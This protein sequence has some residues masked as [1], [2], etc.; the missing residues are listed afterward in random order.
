M[1]LNNYILL[2]FIVGIAFYIPIHH[3]GATVIEVEKEQ[4]QYNRKLENAVDDSLFQLVEKDSSKEVVLNKEKVAE[5]FYQ[6]LCS[7]FGLLTNSLQQERLKQCVPLLLLTDKDGFYVNV[8]T[9]KKD[10]NGNDKI[11]KVWSKKERYSY[12]DETFSYEFTLGNEIKLY[13]KKGKLLLEG[14]YYNF[15]GKYP[16][17]KILNEPDVFEKTRRMCIINHLK[18]AMEKSLKKHNAVATSLGI[19][20]QF[21]FPTIEKEDWY[22][23]IDNISLLVIFQGY[24]LASGKGYFNRY[25]IGGARIWKHSLYYTSFGED[26]TFYYHK[27]NCSKR[28]KKELIYTTKKEC[29]LNGANPCPICRP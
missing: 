2:F 9:I 25:A 12:S 24:P 4:L 6:S 23:T 20:Y 14:D 7:N 5:H 10:K 11:E 19:S 21:F 22:R 18:N 16:N 27:E 26:K 28:G 3:Y 15:A 13:N 29:A 8:T 1:K 17:N